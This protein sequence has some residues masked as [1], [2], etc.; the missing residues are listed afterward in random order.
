MKTEKPPRHGPR[1][2][3]GG[4]VAPPQLGDVSLQTAF[5]LQLLACELARTPDRFGLLAGPFDGRLLEMLLELHLAEDALALKLFLER[6][7]RLFDVV[8]TN[9]DL[10]V[11]FTS[12]LG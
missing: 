8:V 12:F 1:G 9:A 10:L 3:I 11:V 4:R 5:A 6:A 7:K 2:F